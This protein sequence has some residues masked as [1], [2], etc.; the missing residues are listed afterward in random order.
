[1]KDELA[2]L[3]IFPLETGAICAGDNTLFLNAPGLLHTKNFEQAYFQTY[4]YASYEHFKKKELLSGPDVPQQKYDRIFL[5]GTQ[6]HRETLYHMAMALDLLSE[7]GI[8]ICAGLNHEGGKR[9]KKDM[10]KTGLAV[11]DL[12]KFKGRV[13]W[14]HKQD[15]DLNEAILTQWEKDGQKQD[16]LSGRFLSRPGIFGWNKIDAGSSLLAEYM[17]QEISGTVADFGCGYGY[18]SCQIL[19]NSSNITKIHIIDCDSRAVSLCEKNLRSLNHGA[20][21]IPLWSDICLDHQNIPENLDYII[22]NPPFHDGKETDIKRGQ[23]FITS[24]H[25]CLKAGGQLWM[26]A[27]THLPYEKILGSHFKTVCEITQQNGF[28]I[29]H[30]TK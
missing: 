1:M 10:Q 11:H 28:K 6:H 18:L 13:V 16:I 19:E 15:K 27:N 20:E 14:A 29:C 24:A 26:V 5:A 23:A 25:R 12:S 2:E 22:M 8:L 17:P 3:L 21:I 7:G 4:D 30:A 9:L